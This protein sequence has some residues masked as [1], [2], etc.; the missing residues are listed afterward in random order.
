[1]TLGKLKLNGEKREMISQPQGL[2][3]SSQNIIND[4]ALKNFKGT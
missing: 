4:L 1:M 3:Q 2:E